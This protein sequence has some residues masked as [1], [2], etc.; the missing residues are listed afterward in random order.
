M[1]ACKHGGFR[2]MRARR[3]LSVRPRQAKSVRNT[4][5]Y[6][7]EKPSFFFFVSNTFTRLKKKM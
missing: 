5:M 2:L 3:D 7:I 4:G 1:F 6:D